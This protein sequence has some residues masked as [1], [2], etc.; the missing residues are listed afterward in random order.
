MKTFLGI[1]VSTYEN[2]WKTSEYCLLGISTD[3]IYSRKVLFSIKYLRNF[4]EFFVFNFGSNWN[5]S[6][7]IPWNSFW[8]SKLDDKST[9]QDQSFNQLKRFNN[10]TSLIPKS[11]S[12][13]SNSIATNFQ[14][15]HQTKPQA[16]NKRRSHEYAYSLFTTC[17]KKKARQFQK[18]SL[19]AEEAEK[20]N[21]RVDDH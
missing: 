8:T 7:L 6:W 4:K 19:N 3:E 10:W 15:S 21:P 18:N 5:L 16:V 11:P 1:K 2:R 9:K 17:P 12:I 13:L 20:K 14:S